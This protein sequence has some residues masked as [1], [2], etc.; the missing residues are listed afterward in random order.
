MKSKTKKYFNNLNTSRLKSLK[1]LLYKV[2]FSLAIILSVL[3]FQA[4]N[5]KPTKWALSKIKYNIEYKIDFKNSGK[6]VYKKVQ[7]LVKDSKH[8][9]TVFNLD[10]KER[11]PS[12]IKGELYRTYEKGS[13]E[14]IDI[15]SNDEKDPNSVFKGTVKDV[16]LQ[17]KQGYFVV[18]ERENIEMIYGYLSKAHVSKGDSIDIETPVGS[19]GTNKDGNKYLRIELKVDG[20]YKDPLDYIDLK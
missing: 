9:L 2:V 4:I 6:E 7:S 18:V 13:N 1:P 3:A 5:L 11:Y 14:G 8:V 12:P 10:S 16:Y 17:D 19:L 20:A 15:K